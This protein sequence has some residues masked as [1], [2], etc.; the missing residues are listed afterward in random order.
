M[1]IAAHEVPIMHTHH[2][3]PRHDKTRR[4]VK[5]RI[6]WR[7]DLGLNR[8]RTPVIFTPERFKY[9]GRVLKQS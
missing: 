9:S 7:C 2:S 1:N 5:R 6:C 4:R 8:R 3:Y